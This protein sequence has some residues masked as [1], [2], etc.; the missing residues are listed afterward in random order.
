M[1]A[2]IALTAAFSSLLGVNALAAGADYYQDRGR[3]T[4]RA[5]Y[6]D[7][8][9]S[10]QSEYREDGIRL[11]GD[12]YII[13]DGDDLWL[14]IGNLKA[15]LSMLI[16]TDPTPRVNSGRA[17]RFLN[18]INTAGQYNDNATTEGAG[19]TAGVSDRAA[20]RTRDTEGTT[21][22]DRGVDRVR[23]RNRVTPGASGAPATGGVGD[24]NSIVAPAVEIG[25]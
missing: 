10:V 18:R 23:T 2:K 12:A 11:G 22:N 25:R 19:N 24:K 9:Q 16:Y 6:Y 15:K 1:F 21:G 13:K 4:G 5:R 20:D 14:I 3:D 17:E 7:A 8:E